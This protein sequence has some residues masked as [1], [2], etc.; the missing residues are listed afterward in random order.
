MKPTT[1]LTAIAL[2][3]SALANRVLAQDYDAAFLNGCVMDSET[4]FHQIAEVGIINGWIAEI[5][6]DASERTNSIDATGH[7]VTPGFID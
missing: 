3:T 6:T 5:T 1:L 7:V 4:G 2:P